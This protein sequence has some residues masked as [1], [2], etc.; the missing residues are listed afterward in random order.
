MGM[1][2]R[3]NTAG[4][5]RNVRC[6]V[7]DVDGVLT[8]GR[9]FLDGAGGEWKAFDV[10]DGQRL[11]MAREAGFRIVFLTGRTSGAVT[12][13]AEEL[14]VDRVF[15]GAGDKGMV[16]R[17]LLEEENLGEEEVAYLGD[18]LADLPAMRAAGFAGA[19]SDAAP[20]VIE[21][22]DWVSSAGGGRGAAREFVEFVLRSQG[23]WEGAVAKRGGR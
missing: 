3:G 10:K 20:E 7:F 11:V 21:S 2:D 19:V 18:D 4:K 23:L 14:S 13:R 17:R 5:A 15:Q 6:F 22:A 8:D 16:L 1:E 12:R 9:I